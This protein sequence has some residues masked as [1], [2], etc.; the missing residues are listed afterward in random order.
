MSAIPTMYSRVG[1]S[2]TTT[3]T[4]TYTLAG[5]LAGHQ[6]FAAVGNGNT[7]RY[8]AYDVNS[9]GVPN[10]GWETGTGT[11]TASGTT[12][13]RTAVRKSSNSNNA[14]NWSTGTRYLFVCPDGADFPDQTLNTT[15]AV[16]FAG[17]TSTAAIVLADAANIVVNTG[18]GTKIGTGTTQKIGFYNATPIVQ[19]AAVADAT[20]AA[21]AITQLNDL[22][23]RIRAL[24]LIAT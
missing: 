10:G 16:T 13:A 11:Y 12:L 14:V 5:A 23:A 19:G 9:A 6:S 20:D 8:V 1:E 21:S 24:G 4:G 2:S 7:C 22:L 3:G 15:D 18:T 17:V